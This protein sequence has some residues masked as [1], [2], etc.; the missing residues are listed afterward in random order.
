MNGLDNI[1]SQRYLF[2]L[3]HILFPSRPKNNNNNTCENSSSWCWNRV[4]NKK[5]KW[6]AVEGTSICV[7]SGKHGVRCPG[8][9]SLPL[10]FSTRGKP[11]LRPEKWR[12]VYLWG[13]QRA[14]AGRCYA[15]GTNS[16]CGS[17][18]LRLKAILQNQPAADKPAELGCKPCE[19]KDTGF[20][21][22]ST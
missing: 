16:R 17:W 9:W 18:T 20:G 10:Q 2:S 5:L 3:K 13:P 14:S 19:K 6:T 21:G 11:Q 15:L 12:S 22:H 7:R 1:K 4:T 8:A